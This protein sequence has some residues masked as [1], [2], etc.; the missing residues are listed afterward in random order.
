MRAPAPTADVQILAPGSKFAVAP[1]TVVFTANWGFCICPL[2][3]H[4]CFCWFPRPFPGPYLSHLHT[5][6]W[7]F[8]HGC[9][10]CL[11]CKAFCIQPCIERRPLSVLVTSHHLAE[12]TIVFLA[13]WPGE[14]PGCP[15]GSIHIAQEVY[16]LCRVLL[17]CR[18][19][20]QNKTSGPGCHIGYYSPCP[21]VVCSPDCVPSAAP[22]GWAGGSSVKSTYSPLLIFT[23]D[24]PPKLHWACLLGGLLRPPTFIPFLSPIYSSP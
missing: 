4:L 21:P 18:A 9:W 7:V 3:L 15:H 22:S 17:Y 12:S 1:V 5:L 14:L 19:Y 11:C 20:V 23:A 24:S 16:Q 8:S 10:Q 13:G 2:M 6:S